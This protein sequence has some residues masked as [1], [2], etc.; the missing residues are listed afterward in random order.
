MTFTMK[1]HLKTYYGLNLN[2][3]GFRLNDKNLS[4]SKNGIML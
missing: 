4:V 2:A 3:C 1:A